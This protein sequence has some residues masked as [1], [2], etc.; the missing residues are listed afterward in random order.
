MRRCAYGR[1]SLT[2]VSHTNSSIRLK[3]ENSTALQP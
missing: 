2:L 1:S 3:Q